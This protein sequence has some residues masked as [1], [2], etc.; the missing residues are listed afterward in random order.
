MIDC[1]SLDKTLIIRLTEDILIES[2]SF[3]NKEFYSSRF[4]QFN[5][6]GS[7]SYPQDQWTLLGEF[8]AQ[9]NNGWQVFKVKN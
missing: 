1:K 2:L 5:L 6:Y 7:I 4:K 9:D 8:V 3:V